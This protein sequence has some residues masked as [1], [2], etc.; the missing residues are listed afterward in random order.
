MRFVL[1]PVPDDQV[2][3]VMRYIVGAVS[4]ASG[5]PWDR[6]AL[7]EVWGEVD[8]ASRSLLAAVANS[9]LV[10]DGI[11]ASSAAGTIGASV[12]ET[13]A[14]VN[15]LNSIARETFHPNL[16]SARV[17]AEP[18]PNGHVVES[19]TLWMPQDVAEFVAAIASSSAADGAGA[20][21]GG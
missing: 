17:V 4:R 10:E 16:I 11:D 20:S 2:V 9:C 8:L 18:G 1:V 15:E 5:A 3:A 12:R 6:D 19:R 14:I 21:E 13:A 7:A